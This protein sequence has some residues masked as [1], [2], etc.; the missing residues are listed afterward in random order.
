MSN[1]RN[2]LLGNGE[3]LTQ[4]SPFPGGGGPK[5]YPYAIEEIRQAL[6]SPIQTVRTRLH[7]LP[8]S[9]KPRGEAVFQLTLHPAFLG[10][11]YFPEDLLRMSGLRDVGSRQVTIQPRKVSKKRDEGKLLATA[12]LFVAGDEVALDRFNGLLTSSSTPAALKKQFTEIEELGWLDSDSR[13]KGDIPENSDS[14]Q[15]E[16]VLHAGPSEDDIVHSFFVFAKSLGV[17]VDLGRRVQVGGLTFLPTKATGSALKELSQFG[18]LRVARLMPELRVVHPGVTRQATELVVPAL[19]E[20]AP[21]FQ[22]GRAAIFDGGLGTEDLNKWA[23]EFVFSGT[24]KTVGALLQHGNEVT[25]TF[26]FGR[27]DPSN[28]TFSRPYMGVDHYRVLSKDS[29]CDPDL[30]DVLQRIRSVL[31]TGNYQF[32]NLSLGPRLPIGDDE[33]HVWTATLDQIC[34]RHGILAT[35][36]AGN[37]GEEPGDAGRIQPPADMVNSLSVGAADRSGINWARASYSCVGPGRSPGLVKPDG[38]VFGGS[39]KEAF[40]ALNPLLGEIVGVTGTSYASPLA[41]R[42]AA[43]AFASTSYPL[44]TIA[45]KALMVHH[46]DP[47]KGKREELG[48]GRFP[49]DPNSLLDCGTD[50]VSVIFQ[51]QL[52]KGEYLRAPIPFPDV[53]FSGRVELKATLC[54]LAPTDPEHVVN[55]TRAGLQVTFRPRFGLADEGTQDFFGRSSQY[56]TERESREDGHKWETCLHRSKRFDAD[57]E[58]SDPVFDIRYHARQT[59]RGVPPKS[60]PDISYAMVVTIRI[61][62]MPDIYN[63]IRQRYQVL[64]PVALRVG[65]EIPAA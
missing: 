36:A 23:T 3:R 55:Y 13:L 21:L 47:G 2:L 62:D 6:A 54:I 39:D 34:A 19:P 53:P 30:F 41:L 31:D 48:W 58:L 65:I 5:K 11:S 4:T 38:L 10:R 35:V 57:T 15:F 63:V 43:G 18:F 61:E 8:S 56:K 44:S 25:S 20:E 60:A 45:L 64:Q 16:V 32:A 28:P 46:A 37:D 27:V 12:Q 24:E 59:S 22:D 29:G 33:V 17:E 52:A 51:G 49:E 50:S 42:T 9:A 14:H 40:C 26:L 7:N 1:D